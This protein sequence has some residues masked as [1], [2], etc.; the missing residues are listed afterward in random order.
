[1]GRRDAIRVVNIHGYTVAEVVR[2]IEQHDPFCVITDMTGRIRVNMNSGSNDVAQLE[3]VW[4]S[5]RVQAAV[6]N[7]IH[8][9]TIQISV[10]G[11]DMYYPPVRAVQNSKVGVQTTW[12]L[13]IYIGALETPAE[14]QEGVRGISTPKSKMARSGCKDVLQELTFF[15][16]EKN[17]WKQDDE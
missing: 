8:I 15:S 1:M 13:A 12:D 4:E 6:Q 11:M 9:G 7:F 17:T 3:E 10:E 14:G 2:V 16:P 5:M